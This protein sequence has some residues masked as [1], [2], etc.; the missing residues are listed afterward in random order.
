MNTYW[1]CPRDRS[2]LWLSKAL[3]KDPISRWALP[4]QLCKL[5]ITSI[6]FGTSFSEKPWT[7]DKHF[8]ARLRAS[9]YRPSTWAINKKKYKIMW[10][11]RNREKKEIKNKLSK[12]L[13]EVYNNYYHYN[14]A[15]TQ[16]SS[17]NRLCSKLVYIIKSLGGHIQLSFTCNRWT[18]TKAYIN[19]EQLITKIQR[20]HKAFI[21][22]YKLRKI[23]EVDIV[24]GICTYYVVKGNSCEKKNKITELSPLS[25]F[26]CETLKWTTSNNIWYF[27]SFLYQVY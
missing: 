18:T 20:E 25:C 13:N 23:H 9:W 2:V 3:S 5:E 6:L 21:S 17:L 26:G 12:K 14:Y 15:L 19:K 24:I 10:K 11:E 22:S 1:L 4:I 8:C 27:S 7:V 16:N